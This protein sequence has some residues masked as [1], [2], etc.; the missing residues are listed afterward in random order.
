MR[1]E[2]DRRERG[3]NLVEAAI[4]IPILLIILVLVIDLSRAYFTY[5][6]VIDAAR[7]GARYGVTVQNKA[8]MEARCAA[9]AQNQPLPVTI[10][11]VADTGSGPHTPVKVTASADF[12]L[13]MGPLVGR[14]SIPIKH[15]VAFRIR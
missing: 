11:C 15:T 14:S 5:I 4:V 12:K 8:K 13:I 3:A 10:K 2:T 9:E 1:I 7:E 6:T